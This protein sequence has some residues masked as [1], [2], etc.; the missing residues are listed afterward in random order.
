MALNWGTILGSGIA[1]FASGGPVGALV[2]AGAGIVGS[3]AQDIKD[4][5]AQARADQVAMQQRQ[6]Q[7]EDRQHLE[8]YQSP[9]NQM[10]LLRQA[11]INP[12]FSAGQ[13]EAGQTAMPSDVPYNVPDYSDPMAAINL[14][15][16]SILSGEQLKV[17]RANVEVSQ[18]QNILKSR[19]LDIQEKFNDQKIKES[20]ANIDLLAAMRDK[21]KE[22][23]NV[24]FYTAQLMRKDVE[25][26]ED[27][28][29]AELGLKNAEISYKV[30]LTLTE[31]KLRDSRKR[32]LDAQTADLKEHVDLMKKQGKLT[33]QQ[34]AAV[35][36]TWNQLKEQLDYNVPFLQA[37]LL[38][39]QINAQ[40]Y[41]NRVAQL[42]ADNTKQFIGYELEKAKLDTNHLGYFVRNVFAPLVTSF[43]MGYGAMRIGAPVAPTGYVQ[44]QGYQYGADGKL[45]SIETYRNYR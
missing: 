7:L 41:A 12:L 29:R 3:M 34:A 11:G 24:A 43:A 39:G 44:G 14:G 15:Q 16:Q 8:N 35:Y 10:Q 33:D 38:S 9:Q 40:H 45:Q 27:K 21:T 19:E 22:E 17:D 2:G 37:Q 36:Y 20:D 32:N 28:L 42:Y 31:N 23:K 1:G 4:K 13:I 26:Y 30:A 5:K 25:N 6:W 18:A